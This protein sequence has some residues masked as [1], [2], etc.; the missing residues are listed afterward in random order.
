MDA[1]L[2]DML[3]DA[4][5]EHVLAVAEAIHV[6]LDGVR[7]ITVEQQGVLAEHRVDL[8]GLV[9]GIARLHVRGDQARQGAEQVILELD[10]VADDRHG[11]AAEHVGRPHHEGQAEFGGDE[12]ALLDRIGDAV[13]RLLQ[14]QL[15]EQALEPVPVLRE[16]DGVR[17]GAEDR[18]VVLLQRPRELQRRLAAELHDDAVQRPLGA[19]GLDDLQHVLFGQR[20]EIE[21]VRGVVIGR[22]GLGIAID[23]DGLVARILEREAGV[24]AAIIEL[25]ALAD[26]VR[27]AAENDDLLGIGGPRLVGGHARERR[28]VGRVHVG[29]RRGEFGR[30]GIDALE[31][32][33][34]RQRAAQ[35]ANLELGRC[36]SGPRAAHPRSPW[37]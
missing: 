7:E 32:R 28:R 10:L 31:D 17:R 29:G 24:A 36:R 2:L 15:V 20:L 1:R 12:A 19:L 3:H 26:P 21:P 8:A 6:H 16:V 33:A 30:A 11:A 4:G 18:D 34:H 23:H 35:I 14:V 22:D 37:P 25:D 5:D 13:L 27:A 9:V